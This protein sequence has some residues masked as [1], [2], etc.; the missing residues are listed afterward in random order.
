MESDRKELPRVEGSYLNQGSWAQ[1]SPNPPLLISGQLMSDPG[2]SL[3][4]GSIEASLGITSQFN[5]S[6]H[7]VLLPSL[8][9]HKSPDQLLFSVHLASAHVIT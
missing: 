8:P 6:P 5:F 3:P 2:S 4:M 7:P 9:A 1:S